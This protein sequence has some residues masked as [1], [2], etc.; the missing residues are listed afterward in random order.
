MKVIIMSCYGIYLRFNEE[1]S[2]D[3]IE[4]RYDLCMEV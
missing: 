2:S 3:L 1:T 4:E